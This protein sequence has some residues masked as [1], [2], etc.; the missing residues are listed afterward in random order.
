[1]S[2][3]SNTHVYKLS[4]LAIFLIV[5]SAI[6]SDV[7]AQ[8]PAVTEPQPVEPQPSETVGNVAPAPEVAAAP[9][10]SLAALRA[11]IDALTS[12]QEEA[13]AAALLAPADDNTTT[14][15]QTEPIH[16][17]G[18][19][20]FGLDKSFFSK[21]DDGF[22]LLRPTEAT[23]FVFGNLNLYFEANPVEKLRTM[24]EVRLTLAPHGEEVQLGPPL[25]TSYERTD[26]TA[27]DYSSPS[28][29][30]QLRLGGIFIERAWTEYAFSELFKVKWGLFLNPFG[31]W[32]LDHGSPTLISLMLP[33]FIAAQMMPTRLLGIQAGGSK[34]IGSS[35]LGYY[36]HISNGRTPLDFDLSEDKAL[37]LRLY[38]A[39]EGDY[40]RFVLGTSGYFGTYVDQEKK[41]N[42][43][44]TNIFDWTDTIH[45]TE[46]V[47]GVDVA[48]DLGN[49]RLRT[50][51]VLRWVTYKGDLSE[52]I[53]TNDGTIQ[54]LPNRLEY[55]G[56]VLAAYRTPWRLEPYAELEM[57]SKSFTLPR[58]AGATRASTADASGITA[59]LG[60]NVELTTHTLFKTQLAWVRGYAGDF[61]QKSLDLPMLFV[62][63]VQ[64][65]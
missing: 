13:E 30:S 44:G 1:M 2:Q 64:S 15:S 17:Y 57:S 43:V 47:W 26:T 32:N 48:L 50:E 21:G 61:K 9:A 25:G 6:A 12:K 24:I 36:L 54:Y 14:T 18:F 27:F 4:R 28:A 3:H 62:R 39:N 38:I 7:F 65:F 19:M 40:G 58:F 29:Q 46:A 16:I 33:T 5:A 8:A 51:G 60:L 34:F 22:A 59:S 23:T 37:G 49:L 31:I 20:D 63:L 53:F 52:K 11:E 55:S 56:Y 10:D 42:P 45:Y 35:E 41:I